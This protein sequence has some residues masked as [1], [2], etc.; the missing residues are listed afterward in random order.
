MGTWGPGLYCNDI[1]ED[2]K[3]TYMDQ[4]RRGKNNEEI[5]KD[6]LRDYAK[7]IVDAD[8]AINFW[9]ALADTQWKVGR[10]LP[11]VKE[12]ALM[13]LN[14]T[15]PSDVWI[16]TKELNKR[17]IVL[18]NLRN[19]LSLPVPPAKRIPQY[20]LFKC[21]WIIGDTY[22]YKLTSNLSKEKGLYGR[23]VVFRKI[24]EDNW[25]PGHVVPIV[26]FFRWIGNSVPDLCEVVNLGL[27]PLYLY[28]KDEFAYRIK[29]LTTSVKII[30]KSNLTLLGNDSDFTPASEVN[31]L[32]NKIVHAWEWNELEVNIIQAVLRFP[33]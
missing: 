19:Q 18:E 16:G 17:K 12:K 27:L 21:N 4:L 9:L 33:G 32:P 24:T 14:D 15:L 10:L 31:I 23:Y 7:E 30:P 26:H 6:L 2:V 5:V 22:A 25:W 20:R 29:L 1:S 8:D 11:E 28:S 3:N 13:Y